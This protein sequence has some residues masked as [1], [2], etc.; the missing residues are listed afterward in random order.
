MPSKA[1][2]IDI[3]PAKAKTRA[4]YRSYLVPKY[5]I[6]PITHN[7]MLKYHTIFFGGVNLIVSPCMNM[8]G[9]IKRYLYL[10]SW[11]YYHLID[12]SGTKVGDL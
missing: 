9:S 11:S 6:T 2:K 8:Q 7:R 4:P 10:T 12:Y 3:N 5:K 1:D